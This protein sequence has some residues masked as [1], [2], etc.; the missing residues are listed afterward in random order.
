MFLHRLSIYHCNSIYR[1]TIPNPFNP[2][3]NLQYSLPGRSNVKLTIFNILGQT[4]SVIVNQM[5]EAG[6]HTVEWNA[7]NAASGI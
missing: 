1:K 2:S 5:V 4:I 3:T 6:W 7:K